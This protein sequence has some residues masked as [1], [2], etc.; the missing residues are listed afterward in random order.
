[1]KLELLRDESLQRLT[2]YL[3]IRL[4]SLDVVVVF[5]FRDLQDLALKLLGLLPELNDLVVLID[6]RAAITGKCR[7]SHFFVFLHLTPERRILDIQLFR[8]VS[9]SHLA[10]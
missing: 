5:R 2:L 8:K 4:P 10:T 3:G 1:M 9:N 6:L 7:L